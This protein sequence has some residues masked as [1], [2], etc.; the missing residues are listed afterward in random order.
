MSL[1]AMEAILVQLDD[2]GS[3][4]LEKNIPLELVQKGDILKVCTKFVFYFIPY[5]LH[6]IL[7]VCNQNILISLATFISVFEIMSG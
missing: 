1:Q 5:F 3:V 6:N 7:G 4:L 2:D